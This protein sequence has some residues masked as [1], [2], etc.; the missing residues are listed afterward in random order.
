[1]T[2]PV[3]PVVSNRWRKSK[4][5]LPDVDEKF[6][7]SDYVICLEESGQPF[8]GW[9]NSKMGEWYS[10][11]RDAPTLSRRVIWWRPMMNLPKGY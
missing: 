6:G 2:S 8:T 10:S 9:Y 11:Y 7:E 5:H 3:Q 1:M 4:N